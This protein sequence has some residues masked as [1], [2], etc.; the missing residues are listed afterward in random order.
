MYFYIRLVSYLG[1]KRNI[2]LSLCTV[3]FMKCITN[4]ISI[5][6]N[7]IYHHKPA[8][9][10]SYCHLLRPFL[11]DPFYTVCNVKSIFFCL[12]FSITER[13]LRGSHQGDSEKKSFQDPKSSRKGNQN[14]QGEK[15]FHLP[16]K[17]LFLLTLACIIDM[18]L[19]PDDRHISPR[20]IETIQ[21]RN[22]SRTNH[23]KCAWDEI[24]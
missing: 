19:L 20:G 15:C 14:S 21:R 11:S 10:C 2:G 3:P 4:W 13:R 22:R 8:F 16:F 9:F 18:S 12:I 23:V 6:T 24:S 5:L 7:G 1:I 17:K